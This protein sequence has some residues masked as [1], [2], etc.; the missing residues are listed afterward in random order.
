MND[1]HTFPTEKIYIKNKKMPTNPPLN[2]ETFPE[3]RFF[4]PLTLYSITTP[5]DAFEISCI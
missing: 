2:I 4:W 1:F 5:F 3:T